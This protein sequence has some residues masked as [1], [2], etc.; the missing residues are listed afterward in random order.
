MI[1]MEENLF[2]RQLLQSSIESEE[3]ERERIAKNIH[4]DVGTLLNVLKLNLSKITR[5][6]ENKE[7]LQNMAQE[8]LKLLEDAI[9]SIRNISKDL[10]PPTLIRLGYLKAIHELCR[11]I[12]NS[13]DVT[14]DLIYETDP[15]NLP[16]N[17]RVHLY[18]LTQELINNILK[19]TDATDI[20]IVFNKEG[21]HIQIKLTHN[22]KGITDKEVKALTQENKGTGLKSIQ[23]RALM[24]GADIHYFVQSADKSCITV[25]LDI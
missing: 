8:N 20:L 3:K 11:H 16:D 5:N 19:H 21:N 1:H 22:G 10:V 18:R 25:D 17:V 2:Q 6:S 7:L 24:L 12:S 13:G 4:D 23:G 15:G 9:Q 14:A